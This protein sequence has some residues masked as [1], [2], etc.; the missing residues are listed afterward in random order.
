MMEKFCIYNERFHAMR[1]AKDILIASHRG[2]AGIPIVD[3][4]VESF[5]CAIAQHADILEMDI[6]MS[7]DGKLFVIHDGMELRLFHIPG[8]VQTM[9]GEQIRH[10][11]YFNMNA[12]HT[13]LHPNT[14]DEVLECLKDRCMLNFD[15]SWVHQNERLKWKNIFKTVARHGMEDQVIYKTPAA[16]KYAEMFADVDI[17]YLYMPMVRCIDEVTPFLHASVN[18]V[19]AEVHFSEDRDFLARPEHYEFLRQKGIYI[20]ANA[21][22]LGAS[23][24]ELAGGHDDKTAMLGNP[25][26][27]WGY[28]LEQGFDIVQSDY[29]P[30]IVQYYRSRGCR[31]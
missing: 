30:Q 16:P 25:D 3:N 15:R 18:I 10:L 19:A 20:W 24:G 5:E 2:S 11:E 31:I 13:G 27:G 29:V 6:S 14:L 23:C 9:T 26:A 8:N 12:A 17:P 7:T 28:F 21:L 1:A 4:T 22:T